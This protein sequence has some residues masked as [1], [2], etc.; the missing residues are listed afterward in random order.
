MTI[1]LGN[2][3]AHAEKTG[4]SIHFFNKIR[5]NLRSR[6]E[7]LCRG[8]ARGKT[9]ETPPLTRRKQSPCPF[10]G[11]PRR[12]TS[13][14]AEKTGHRTC[15]ISIDQKHLRSRGEN[16]CKS[17]ID[18]DM[19]ETPP[20][21]RRKLL[22]KLVSLIECG[23]TSAHAE[24]TSTA[25]TGKTVSRKHLRSR[26]ENLTVA[27][28][29]SQD[30]ET[31]PLTRR[32]QK[33]VLIFVFQARNTSAHAEKTP[34][35]QAPVDGAEKHLRSRGENGAGFGTPSAFWET[36][37]LTRRK[38]V[39]VAAWTFYEGNTSAHAEKTTVI[40]QSPDPIQKHLRSRGEN[41]VL[42]PVPARLMETP[43]LTRRKPIFP[44]YC[45][46]PFRNTSAHAEKTNT[47]R[48]AFREV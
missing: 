22:T 25:R 1:W 12:N 26:G 21:T 20:L 6:G 35:P 38:P 16:L 23:N 19:T 31:P 7:N 44:A 18:V 28:S 9:I 24:K 39:L 27:S 48:S 45:G 4:F 17:D 5:K 40:N 47:G 2:T 37:P 10:P 34:P 11:P 33:S 13:A 8:S 3:S 43:P 41:A 14:H 46:S 42:P 30:I 15:F 29:T 32:K 36:P